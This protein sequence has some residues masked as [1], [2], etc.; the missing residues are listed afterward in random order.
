MEEQREDV[1]AMDVIEI[2]G[3][4]SSHFTRM[5]RIFAEELRVPYRLVPVPDMTVLSDEAYGGNPAMKL[6]VL[7]MN[8]S[9]LFGAQNIC[10][11]IAGRSDQ[12][13]RIIW[14][15]DLHDSLSCNAQELVWHGMAVQVQL[16][17]GTLICKLPA[18]N[19]YFVKAREGFNGTLVWLDT[20]L[21]DVRGHLPPARDLSLFEVALFC[22]VDHL[23]FR[24]TVSIAPY[25]TLVSFAEEF[26]KR[27]SARS[28]AYRF[29]S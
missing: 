21:A 27:S 2:I 6:P 7:R 18:D 25:P 4:S 17:F 3:R 10:R 13:A 8:G 19:V 29:D 1:A 9:T 26:G 5:T 24:P 20:H 22:L 14:P 15:E 28:T 12:P 11:A 23:A 16:A